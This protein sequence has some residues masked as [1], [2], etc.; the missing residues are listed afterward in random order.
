MK[1]NTNSTSTKPLKYEPTTGIRA[2]DS[3]PYPQARQTR[4]STLSHIKISSLE[5]SPFIFCFNTNSADRSNFWFLR[6][7][8][9]IFPFFI[10]FSNFAP[11]CGFFYLFGLYFFVRVFWLFPFCA[12][13][14]FS[15]FC[16]VLQLIIP[17][18][19]KTIT[20][21]LCT[22][23]FSLCTTVPTFLR[24]AANNRTPTIVLKGTQQ[25]PTITQISSSNRIDTL[26]LNSIKQS[27][28]II[29]S[30]RS[31]YGT[32]LL[33]LPFAAQLGNV[34]FTFEER[35]YYRTHTCQF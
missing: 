2:T 6:S 35:F 14:R 9:L 32:C 26:R 21:T 15:S 17:L 30:S 27:G 19:H 11:F 1:T 13:L 5:H 8:T 23:S 34:T 33:Q 18:S 3:T 29:D 7:F 31:L 20:S 22:I 24:Y 25:H 16:F 4:T 10:G 28:I 12:F